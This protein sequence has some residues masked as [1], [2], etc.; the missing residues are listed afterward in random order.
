[1]KT[2]QD[3]NVKNKRVLVRCDFNVPLDDQGNILDDFRIRQTV[4]TIKYFL[5]KKDL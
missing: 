1:M 5:N 2:I 3:F 4:P